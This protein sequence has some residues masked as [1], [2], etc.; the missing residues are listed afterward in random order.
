MYAPPAEKKKPMASNA[1]QPSSKLKV[2]ELAKIA[3][4][5]A[6]TV[7]KVINGRA[8]I[9]DETRRQVEQV[10]HKHGYSRPLV[11]TK[12]SPT[13][14]LVVEYI[15]HNGTM[16][17]IKY[18]SYWAQQAGLAI[19]VTQTSNGEATES[20]FRGIIDR[21][22]QGV[23]MQQMGGLNN[24]AKTLFKSRNIPIVIIDPVD[25]VDSD[26]MSVAIDNWT[27]GYQA[28]KH[29]LALGH[30]NI[31]VI[32]GPKNLQTG[33]ARYSGF[34]AA[35]QQAD[36]PLPAEYV[37]QGDYFPAEASYRA[38]CELIELPNRPTAIFCCNDLSA[39][40]TYRA[41]REH[42]IHLPKQLSIM[43]FDDIFPAAY[44][45]PSLSSIHQPFS[46]IA[47]RAVRMIVDTREGVD[48]DAHVVFPTS[49]VT[50]E[51]TVPPCQK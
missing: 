36:V 6:S 17:L 33:I 28:G 41:A 22:P 19:T 7:S 5:S 8:G 47:Q 2:S 21:N 50:R 25:T 11:S 10:L 13:I 20:C 24:P 14:E 44:L 32:R 16:E 4:V 34:A 1:P 49:V 39:V 18:A 27:A 15:A 45:M 46:E 51:S 42:R 31:G 3:G 12:L 23:I 30:R 9:S 35:L 43:G 29:L 26:V 37:R 48:T 40:N 38:A